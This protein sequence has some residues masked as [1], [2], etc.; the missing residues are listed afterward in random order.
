MK[1]SQP[2]RSEMTLGSL[3]LVAGL[4]ALSGCAPSEHRPSSDKDIRDHRFRVAIC[5][6][7]LDKM[8][9]PA[10]FV[11]AQRLGVRPCCFRD[12][13]SAKGGFG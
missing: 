3:G 12:P 13:V 4:T 10:A 7:T 8:S 5:D 11:A 9:N 2:N 6:W 1:S